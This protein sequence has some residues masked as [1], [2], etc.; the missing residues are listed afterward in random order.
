MLKSVLEGHV[1]FYDKKLSKI[2]IE[3]ETNFEYDELYH[4]AFDSVTDFN[5]NSLDTSYRYGRKFFQIFANVIKATGGENADWN[6]KAVYLDDLK[7]PT[8]IGV[9][10]YVTEHT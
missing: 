3:K 9:I 4:Y 2:D 10:G 5:R 7:N 8:V 1:D 6:T